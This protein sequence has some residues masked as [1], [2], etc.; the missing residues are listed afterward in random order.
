VS[1]GVALGYRVIQEYLRQGE[2]VARSFWPA[3]DDD[4][5]RNDPSRL[6]DR[7]L[8]SAQ[9]LAGAFSEMVRVFAQNAPP[10]ANGASAGGFDFEAPRST[11]AHGRDNPSH[12]GRG[13]SRPDDGRPIVALSVRSRR[14]VKVALQLDEAAARGV[15]QVPPLSRSG[16]GTA[17]LHGVSIA[18]GPAGKGVAIDLEVRP[19]LAKGRYQGT[20]LDARTSRPVG[21]LTIDVG[22]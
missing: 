3:G 1:D 4:A 7:A 8:R 5:G 20:V 14:P 21:F 19:R 12:T 22:A 2:R 11:K 18:A 6:L 16:S 15:L 10:P 13:R 17:R 9:D